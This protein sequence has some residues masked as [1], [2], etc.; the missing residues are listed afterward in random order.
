M[1]E[2]LCEGQNKPCKVFIQD[3]GKLAKAILYFQF[4]DRGAWKTALRGRI[5]QSVVLPPFNCG[6]LERPN[7]EGQILNPEG[8]ELG[9]K[10]AISEQIIAREGGGRSG[11]EGVK[12]VTKFVSMKGLCKFALAKSEEKKSFI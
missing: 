4:S 6:D 7:G 2:L 10:G 8:A 5:E 9:G 3:L 12:N 1:Q 11:G